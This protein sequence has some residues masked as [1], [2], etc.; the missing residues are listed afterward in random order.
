MY[1]EL[2]QLLQELAELLLQHDRDAEAKKTG[3]TKKKEVVREKA[4][5][6]RDNAM[7]GL[8]ERTSTGT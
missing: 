2:I 4:E 5:R 7:K 1:D 8:V 6:I 3:A